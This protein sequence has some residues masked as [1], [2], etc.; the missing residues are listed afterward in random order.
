M[1]MSASD[2]FEFFNPTSEKEYNDVVNNWTDA[3]L[4]MHTDIYLEE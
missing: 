3:I 1:D 2:C 4:D